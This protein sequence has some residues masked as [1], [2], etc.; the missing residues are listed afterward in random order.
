VIVRIGAPVCVAEL[1]E[2]LVGADGPGVDPATEATAQARARVVAL[3]ADGDASLGVT[4]GRGRRARPA[5][6]A[7]CRAR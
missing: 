3:V 4:P 5:P 7:R 1:A 2:R 6:P